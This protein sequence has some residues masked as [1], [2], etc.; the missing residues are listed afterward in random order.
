MFAS[1]LFFH[2]IIHAVFFSL[3]LQLDQLL[4][5][6]YFFL[7]YLLFLVLICL[8]IL[9]FMILRLFLGGSFEYNLLS[10]RSGY[11]YLIPH[12]LSE[13]RISHPTAVILLADLVSQNARHELLHFRNHHL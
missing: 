7:T 10:T 2:C 1:F 6:F 11:S 9:V 8:L 13:G 12:H 5:C 4:V 3:I